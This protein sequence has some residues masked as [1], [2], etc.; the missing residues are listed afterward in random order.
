MKLGIK[1][2]ACPQGRGILVVLWRMATKEIRNR[3]EKGEPIMVWKH[4]KV[5]GDKLERL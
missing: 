3:G 1:S 5:E 4:Y 2:F